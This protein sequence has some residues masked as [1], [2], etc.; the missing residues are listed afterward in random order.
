MRPQAFKLNAGTEASLKRIRLDRESEPYDRL[1]MAWER[2]ETWINLSLLSLLL[3]LPQ[4]ILGRVLGTL[5]GGIEFINPTLAKLEST[6]IRGLVGAPDVIVVDKETVALVEVKVKAQ[7]TSHRY[8]FSQYKKYMALASLCQCTADKD[9]A[10]RPHHLLVVPSLIPQEFCS[11]YQAW[12]PEIHNG[13]LHVDP[14]RIRSLKAPWE[15][16]SGLWD[17]LCADLE[18]RDVAKICGF[19]SGAI[20]RHFADH[21]GAPAPTHVVTWRTFTHVVSTY[22]REARLLSHAAAAESLHDMAMRAAIG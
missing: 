10:R 22:C 5:L 15:A 19:E 3:G 20:K 16:G 9:L 11:D 8:S 13:Q 12:Q 7:K 2:E 21:P 6:K 17:S 4:E 1:R 18:S 14:R